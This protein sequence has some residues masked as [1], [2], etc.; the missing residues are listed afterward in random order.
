MEIIRNKTID[1]ETAVQAPHFNCRKSVRS[2]Y[3]RLVR[4]VT[5]E[6]VPQQTSYT[7]KI[8]LR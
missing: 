7:G 6:P 8:E 1:F 2:G 4:I 3:A 5:N